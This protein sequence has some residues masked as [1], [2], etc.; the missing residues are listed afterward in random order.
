MVLVKIDSFQV[1]VC[2]CPY[3]P[4]AAHHP[5]N[6]SLKLRRPETGQNSQGKLVLGKTAAGSAVGA[7]L[8]GTCPS[9]SAMPQ[10]GAEGGRASESAALRSV[11]KQ[12]R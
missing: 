11:V 1:P 12:C 10:G 4:A 5:G 8:D 9:E 3:L 6:S 2:L 7:A